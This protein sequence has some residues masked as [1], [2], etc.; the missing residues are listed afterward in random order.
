MLRDKNSGD[1][2]PLVA[3]RANF[4]AKKIR[5]RQLN[6]RSRSTIAFVDASCV[7]HVGRDDALR[8]EIGLRDV[9]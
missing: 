8:E 5:T 1:Y 9:R 2:S 7:K 6:H 4:M 3:N